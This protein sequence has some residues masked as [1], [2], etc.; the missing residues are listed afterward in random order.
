MSNQSLSVK[1]HSGNAT[2]FSRSFPA[3]DA[4]RS[5][6]AGAL[7]T[8]LREA[9]AAVNQFLTELVVKSDDKDEEISDDDDEEEEEEVETSETKNPESVHNV[10]G[11]RKADKN[12][13]SPATS[14]RQEKRNKT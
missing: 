5:S 8:S 12:G 7:V 6:T 9:Q 1:V 4:G 2:V 3:G 11:K 10:S 13:S 14:D